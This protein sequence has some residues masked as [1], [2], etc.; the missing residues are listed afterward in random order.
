MHGFEVNW[1]SVGM[2]A[3]AKFAIGAVWFS[4]VAFGPMWRAAVGGD[5][6]AM[7]ARFPRCMIVDFAGC[8][9]TAWI[10]A[11]TLQFMGAMRLVSG[12]RTAFFLWLGLVAPPLLSSQ[13]Y[14]GRPLRLFWIT[15]LYWLVSLLAMGAIIGGG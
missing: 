8:L 1:S 4:P 6:D 14:E 7:K 2:A 5:P 13:Q 15:G 12:M 10:L 11:N 9:I 3:V